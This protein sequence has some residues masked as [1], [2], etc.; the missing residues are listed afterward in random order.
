M[1]ALQGNFLGRFSAMAG[2]ERGRSH[3]ICLTN[4][5][6]RI[7]RRLFF[8]AGLYAYLMFTNKERLDL[9]ALIFFT[10]LLLPI[11]C[12]IALRIVQI[13]R[14]IRRYNDHGSVGIA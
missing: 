7:L 8:L 6:R 10:V 1:L 9:G 12:W 14:S 5:R 11:A 4:F 2:E 13:V 3:A